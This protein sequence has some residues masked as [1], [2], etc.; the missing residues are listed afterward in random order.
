MSASGERGTGWGAVAGE[1][2]VCVRD[3]GR[4]AP[5]PGAVAVREASAF[6]CVRGEGRMPSP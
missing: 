3:P 5:C 1:V 4:G 6:G 2:E